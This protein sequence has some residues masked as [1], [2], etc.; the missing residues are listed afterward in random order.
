MRKS[1]PGLEGLYDVT[2]DGRIIS[3][4]RPG[5][6]CRA[7]DRERCQRRRPDGY[8]DVGLQQDGKWKKHLVHRLVAQA[9][10]PNPLGLPCVNHI[11]RD[12]SNNSVPN[13]E[14]CDDS[15]NAQHGWNGG[16][17]EHRIQ[18][19]RKRLRKFTVDDIRD[20]RA[21]YENGTRINAL[22]KE[23]GVHF[24]TVRGIVMKQSYCEVV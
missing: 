18:L 12:R 15:Y 16:T 22:A 14:W 2:E 20:I 19:I 8:Y 6:G 21:A 17:R 13:L 10:I 3:C 4:A 9:F 23:R 1:I 24:N 11:D 7:Y 5:K